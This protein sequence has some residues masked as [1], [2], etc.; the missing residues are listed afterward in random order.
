MKFVPH[1]PPRPHKQRRAQGFLPPLPATGLGSAVHRYSTVSA[2]A[3]RTAVVRHLRA[4]AAARRTSARHHP[5]THAPFAPRM[6]IRRRR[7]CGI[8]VA[9]SPGELRPAPRN[10]DKRSKLW[11]AGFAGNERASRPYLSPCPRSP[12]GGM[13]AIS[14]AAARSSQRRFSRRIMY[15]RQREGKGR[16]VTLSLPGRWDQVISPRRVKHGRLCCCIERKTPDLDFKI[17]GSNLRPV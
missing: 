6:T 7:R 13:P 14:G 12:A 2:T 9:A 1:K 5:R 4:L 11:A 8:P 10:D 3:G 17:A 15:Q 16:S